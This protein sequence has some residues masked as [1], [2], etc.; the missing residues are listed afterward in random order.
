[1]TAPEL[2]YAGE[3]LFGNEWR[4]SLA[5]LLRQ[6]L[7]TIQR[8]ANGQNEIPDEY[9]AIVTQIMAATR[10]LREER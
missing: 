5:K 8:W 4:P 6:N 10:T 2:S 3:Q 7:R 1:M 9:A